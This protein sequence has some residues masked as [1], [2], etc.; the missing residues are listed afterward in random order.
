MQ[1][2]VVNNLTGNRTT[3]CQVDTNDRALNYGD[4]CFTTMYAQN[5][6]V[7]LLDAHV[8]RLYRDAV[9]LGFLLTHEEL[10]KYVTEHLSSIISDSQQ[11]CVIKLLL[12]RGSG[13][14][15]YALPDEPRYKLIIS[16]T[17][18]D[19]FT[20][21]NHYEDVALCLGVASIRLS[22]Q[23]QLAGIKHLNRL[24]QIMAKRELATITDCDDLLMLAPNEH[25]IEATSANL[26]FYKDKQWYT[27]AL[28]NCGVAGVMREALIAYFK[29][30]NV[31]LHVGHYTLAQV[32][33]A[34][35]LCL[36]NAIRVI[37]PVKALAGVV[38]SHYQT[39]IY[40]E[41]LHDFYAFICSD[42]Y[43]LKVSVL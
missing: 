21:L 1:V 5:G 23:P 11:P 13:G 10:S 42:V 33:Q 27:P 6:R 4:G 12:S 35:C 32:A 41:L 2:I 20:I 37:Q 39:D 8:Q 28:D 40:A 38:S 24:E 26:F 36:T 29:Q 30:R 9:R 7:L 43:Q 16:I 19:A 31:T 34:D 14:R 15:G 18:I 17:P 25:V 22:H 3:N